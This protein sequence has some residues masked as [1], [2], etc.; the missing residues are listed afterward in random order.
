MR[1]FLLIGAIVLGLYSCGTD[2]NLLTREEL[3]NWSSRNDTIFYK[4][5]GVAVFTHFEIELYRGKTDMEIC[6][7]AI[8]LDTMNIE[9]DI[10]RYVHTKHPKD[11]VQFKPVYEEYKHKK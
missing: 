6:L 1:K 7:S 3:P 5:R 11:K 8:D 10:I 2:K 4:N 9:Y